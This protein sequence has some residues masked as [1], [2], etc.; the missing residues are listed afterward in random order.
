MTSPIPTWPDASTKEGQAFFASARELFTLW[1][2]KVGSPVIACG[3]IA[4]AE[5]ESAFNPNACGDRGK[6]TGE[7]TAFGLH[8]RHQDRLDEILKATGIN[9]KARVL[10][11]VN[12]L[13]IE[14]EATWWELRAHPYLGLEALRNA[15]T[16]FGAGFQATWRFERAGAAGA[17]VRR[18]QMAQRWAEYFGV[19][20]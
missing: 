5:A 18:G 8:Q 11:K 9:I 20:P 10:A 4:Q 17:C 1:M 12:T 7:P 6:A 3:I 13:P 2:A 19:N 16:P 14:V 15:T